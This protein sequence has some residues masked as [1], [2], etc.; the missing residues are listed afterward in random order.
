MRQS[1]S[2][3][4]AAGATYASENVARK[5]KRATHIW[6]KKC[7]ARTAHLK[8]ANYFTAEEQEFRASGLREPAW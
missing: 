6:T 5:W 7:A 1:D 4:V 3:E 8:I 2:E